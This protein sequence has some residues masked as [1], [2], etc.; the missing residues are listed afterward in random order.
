VKERKLLK[1]VL[2]S[3]DSDYVPSEGIFMSKI[4]NLQSIL[5]T[6]NSGNKLENP[7][8]NERVITSCVWHVVNEVVTANKFL[9]FITDFYFEPESSY[10]YDS[11]I[12]DKYVACIK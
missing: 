5:R 3:T 7:F 11:V 6:E 8:F 12:S 2:I 9:F 4:V 10:S 1:R